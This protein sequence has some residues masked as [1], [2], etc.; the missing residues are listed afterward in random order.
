MI[1]E[2]SIPRARQAGGA[3]LL[4]MIMTGVAF[5]ILAGAMMWAANSTRLTHRS[6]QHT[7][8]VLAAEAA[9][10]KVVSRIRQD[11]L[12]GGEKLVTD[13][14]SSYRN[15]VPTSTDSSFWSKWKFTSP[16]G[17]TSPTHVQRG[18]NSNYVVLNSTYAGLRGYVSTYTVISHA[19]EAAAFQDV[20]AGV[21]Q[22]VQLARI[23]V[24]QFAM[25]S[26]G[27]MEISCG[28]PFNVT[29]RVH[30]NKELYVEPDNVLTFQSDVT[31]VNSIRFQRH[32]LDTRSAPSGSAVYQ[33]RKD[34]RVGSMTLPIGTTNTPEAIRQIIMPPP[35]GEDA[36]SPMG[37]LRYYNQADMILV[38]SNSGLSVA[39][40]SFNSLNT[41]VPQ[42][43]LSGFVSTNNSFRD[44]REGKTVRPID[45]NIGLLTEWSRTNTS[46][47]PIFGSRDLSS[48]Y[49]L[50][51]RTLASTELSAVRL[52]N[53]QR[54]PASGLTVA[55]AR[56]LYVWGHYNQSDAGNLGTTNTITTKPA[57]LAADAIMILS[58]AWLDSRSTLDVGSRTAAPTTVNA[59]L[60]TGAVDT[61][62][63]NY[64]G[65]MENFPR[66]LETW[67]SA[68]T[69]TYNG[70]MVKMFPSQYATN[71]WR[72]A[73]VY[74]PPKR[75]W[76]FD[77]N[78]NDPSKLP[79][80]TPSLQKVIRGRWDTVT[81]NHHTV[82]TAH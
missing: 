79:P 19:Q 60:L 55:T 25:Y 81:P 45:I 4:T 75:N 15:T 74:S 40:V 71:V 63:G 41:A 37:R 35:A 7:R 50:D 62:L 23:P 27:D 69:F 24:F 64:S 28:Q 12:H 39:S 46:A 44:A 20:V 36:S 8:T 51:R 34:A 49:V 10:E 18:L 67:G 38:V 54:L 52:V 65:G 16:D 3:L 17:T 72:T 58:T 43:E 31:A 1:K 66:F 70:S 33:A 22:E 42:S 53:G 11:Y 56:P 32:P 77:L 68:N 29:G 30:S 26:S 82:V 78:F 80:L 5:A 76:A 9:T 13:N 21:L 2:L 59:A 73:E 57:S 14:L 61:T 47:R 6:I 48:L